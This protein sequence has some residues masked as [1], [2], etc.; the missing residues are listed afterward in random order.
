MATAP[1]STRWHPCSTCF[2][3]NSRYINFATWNAPAWSLSAEWWAYVLFPFLFLLFKRIGY[4]K[5]YI[6]SFIAI[7]GWLTIEFFLAAL[8]P[9]LNYPLNPENKTLDVNWHYGTLRGIIGFIAGMSIW[10]LYRVSRFKKF[11]GNGWVLSAIVLC[12][13]L[14]MQFKFYDTVTV[15][16]FGILILSSAYGSA[17]INKFYSWKV[18]QN[19]GKWSFSIY[20]W[21][22]VLINLILLYYI[23]DLTEPIKGLLR[24]LKG[25]YIENSIYLII[26]L[27][28]TS[29]IGY[30]SYRFLEQPTRKWIKSKIKTANN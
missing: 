3:R 13:L 25:S 22:M 28:F 12:S 26:F 9:F 24:P 5:W 21:H 6:V 20:M 27:L 18:F 8:H 17:S 30:L 7:A 1:L 14:S 23:V 15:S 19:L 4:K 29:L 16:L 11:L 2:L 10:E